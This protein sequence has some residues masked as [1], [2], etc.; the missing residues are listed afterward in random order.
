MHLDIFTRNSGDPIRFCENIPINY[1]FEPV[2]K[3]QGR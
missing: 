1:S 2:L 3:R